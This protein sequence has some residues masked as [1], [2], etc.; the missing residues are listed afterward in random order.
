MST[1]R[2]SCKVE[3]T[4]PAVPLDFEILLDSACVF[5]QCAVS[6]AINIKIDIPDDST[7]H[8][9]RFCLSG[10]TPEHTKLDANNNMV[11]D[12]CLKITG[13]AFDEIDLTAILPQ[14]AVYYH[15]FN[16][17]G[18]PTQGPFYEIMGCNG[19]VDIEFFTPVYLWLLENM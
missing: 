11:K 9:L 13:I 7:Q 17:T 4:D 8:Q 19:H 16:G 5:E 18:K 12:A 1:V 3:A 14:V 10:K 6:N 2:F 15:D